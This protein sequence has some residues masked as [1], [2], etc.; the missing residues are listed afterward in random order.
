MKIR[1][2]ITSPKKLAAIT[3]LCSVY[4]P[5]CAE[6]TI[7]KL[8]TV[9]SYGEQTA[10][11][12][13]QQAPNSVVVIEQEQIERFNDMTAGDVL[14]R[15][16]GVLF[17]GAPGENKDVRIRGLDKEYSQILIN[18]RR[19]PGGGEKRE[20][21][22]DQLPAKFI[23][24]I[25][26]IRAP[27]AEIDAQGI[28]GTINIILKTTPEEPLF[29]ITVGASQLKGGDTKPNINMTYGGQK[30][31]FGYLLN[32]NVQQRQL[33]K[34]S[35]MQSFK[36][37][38]SAEKSEVESED[39]QF[40]ELQFAPSINWILSSHDQ[41]SLEPFLLVSDEEKTKEKLKFKNDGSIDGKELERE[42]KQRSNWALYGQWKHQ[43]S[44]A[45]E[46][47]VG[48]NLQE[49]QEDKE[50]VKTA[51]KGADSLDKTENETEDKSDKEWALTLKNK[52]FIGEQHTLI[53]GFEFIDK[54]RDK[55]KVKT[56]TKN[57]KTKTKS[58]GKDKYHIIERRFNAYILDEYSLSE[59]QL[60]TP[61]MRFEWTDTEVTSSTDAISKSSDAF[62][63]P[64]L[65]YLFNWTDTTNVRASITN[66]VRRPKFD[67]LAPYVDSKDGTVNKPDKAGNPDLLP[68]TATGFDV[69]I[70]HYF[71]K[72]AG[73]IGINVFYRDI[74]DKIETRV[75]FNSSSERYEEIPENVG[76]AVLKGIEFDTSW[77]MAAYGLDGLTFTANV[78]FLDGEITDQETGN[79][80][81]F[82]EQPDYVYNLGFDHQISSVGVSWGMNFNQ[83]SAR[84]SDEIKDGKQTVE[85]LASQKYLD[86]YIKK[87]FANGSELRFS[88]QNLLEAEKEKVRT[89][90]KGDGSIDRFEHE[91]EQSNRLVYL[92][93]TSRW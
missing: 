17:G 44:S 37:D 54:E 55:N 46:F 47:T 22:L 10:L 39:K 8:G 72:Q 42:D 78:T 7:T 67:D 36:V 40:D 56:E 83:I 62:W 29:S 93:F 59:R 32:L 57:G 24:R 85:L 87:S 73:N 34:N 71:A 68:E 60:L 90:F 82:K 18:G 2:P 14:R 77:N 64:S 38:G 26:V 15:L 89:I 61:G 80:T 53:T 28:A 76:E 41:L 25:E 49:S 23:E 75:N 70:E 88:A 13:R 51:F 58:E 5:V 20:F 69:G 4:L 35:T 92:S 9:T 1:P 45:N 43:Y 27:T 84:E 30:D 12:Q 52:G 91:L 33:L 74:D 79:K 86:L 81:P 21:Q 3:L 66:T 50:K 31:D 65:H 6:E 16:P 63:S 48:L 19:I 11:Q